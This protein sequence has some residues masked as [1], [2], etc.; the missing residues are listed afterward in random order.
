MSTFALRKLV[1][2]EDCGHQLKILKPGV[3]Q[4][5][6]PK[7]DSFFSEG[8][9]IEAIVGKNGSGKTTL[10]DMLFRM[11]NNL[12]ALM[13]KGYERPAADK[14]YFIKGVV[15]D[16]FYTIDGTEGLLQCRNDSVKLSYKEE[17]FQWFLN[18]E[19]CIHKGRRAEGGEARF[20][21]EVRATANFFYTIAT[22]YSLQAYIS[23]DYSSEELLEWD[24]E[25]GTWVK[26]HEDVSWIDGVFHKNDG[27]MSPLVLNPY[28]YAGSIDMVKEEGLTTNRLCAILWETKFQQDDS[29]MIEGYRLND[30]VYQFDDFSL[31]RKFDE[32][33]LR[34]LPE[35][36]FSNKFIYCYNQDYSIAKTILESYG[37]TVDSAL[38]LVEI[39]LRIYLSYKTLSIAEKY[40]SYT[41]F[42]PVGDINLVFQSEREAYYHNLV[43]GLVEGIKG[44]HS[45]IT[46]K[47]RKTLSLI[48]GIMKLDNKALFE[49][50]FT[51]HDYLSI[52]GQPE[53]V[54]SVEE[55]N[56][57]LPPPVFKAN[58]YLIKNK[59]YRELKEFSSDSKYFN[60]EC[61]KKAIRLH[62]LS[63]GERQLI[64]M[65]S[66]LVYHALNLI[67]IPE[68]VRVKYKHTLMVLD[69]IEIC[70]HPDYQRTFI[71]NLLA[72]IERMKLTDLLSINVLI[73]THSPFILSDIPQGNIMYLEDGAQ[74]SSYEIK[75]RGIKNPFC[76]N[77]NDI[78]HQSFFLDKGFVGEFAKRKVLSLAADLKDK[79]AKK[80]SREQA[81]AF[82]E[83]V[84]EPFIREHLL[85]LYFEKYDIGKENKI[86]MYQEEIERLNR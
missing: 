6:D 42:K 79:N 38:S 36:S 39:T 18:R 62:D 21:Q 8:L 75:Q 67:S 4:F 48:E 78:L 2:N 80:W 9:V 56:E 13:F 29:Q 68:T 7:Y 59:D 51:Y 43:R 64:Y 49:N 65:S 72:L 57:L 1:V 46:V 74:L 27:Y 53:Q 30:I 81:K 24:K 58:I 26:P 40:P 5:S 47:I 41:H 37:L 60:E 10:L 61:W 70:F 33:L 45:H 76:A 69:E 44:D 35:G 32:K 84:G 50:Q 86:A 66:T 63:S 22:N 3:Y 25:E 82:I 71:S 85:N 15:A 54:D 17:S 28:R 34:S 52:L 83:E 11:S 55:R 31:K 14:I 73:V 19:G 20:H 23:N 77:I 16:L 12:A